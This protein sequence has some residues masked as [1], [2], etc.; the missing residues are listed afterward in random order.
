MD[1]LD[2]PCARAAALVGGARWRVGVRRALDEPVRR[3][4]AL[5][6]ARLVRPRTHARTHATARASHATASRA[7]RLY[8]ASIAAFLAAALEMG[9]H[10]GVAQA[11]VPIGYQFF[12]ALFGVILFA[13]GLPIA[14]VLLA[15]SGLYHPTW[16]R[17]RGA[18][19]LLE[20]PLAF[21]FLFLLGA[22]LFVGPALAFLAALLRLLD[23]LVEDRWQRIFVGASE[24]RGGYRVVLP[25]LPPLP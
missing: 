21:G 23:W 13:N 20:L 22:G 16:L 25:P 17:A 2:D 1:V 19:A 9:V 7:R 3:G 4:D 24:T 8:D 5:R 12:V 6:A 15:W 18:W 14:I 10:L 11:G